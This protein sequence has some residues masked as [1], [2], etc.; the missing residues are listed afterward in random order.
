MQKLI[1][2]KFRSA[3][4]VG[5]VV[6]LFFYGEPMRRIPQDLAELTR[7]Q[8]LLVYRVEQLEK[9]LNSKEVISWQGEQQRDGLRKAAWPLSVPVEK[10]G[11]KTP[12]NGSNSHHL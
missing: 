8:S 12:A 9:Q 6:V 2:N 3:S 7:V 5:F 10:A 11:V 4:V 1:E